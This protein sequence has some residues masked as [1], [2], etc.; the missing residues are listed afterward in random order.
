M[1]AQID[2][3]VPI[4]DPERPLRRTLQSIFTGSEGLVRVLV[5]A[6]NT[7]PAPFERI[8]ADYPDADLF[9]LNDGVR[10]PS[11]PMN[12]GLSNARAPWVSIMGSDDTV[13]A[14][15]YREW[16]DFARRTG[17]DIVIPRL[18]H[19]SGAAVI[20]PPTRPWR[21]HTLDPV[22]DRLS[23][24]SA[25]L[26]IFSRE[27]FGHARLP[28]G[29][30]TGEDIPFVTQLWFSGSRVGYAR[31]G[32]AYII[33]ADAGDRISYAPRP[34]EDEFAW[35]EPTE[36]LAENLTPRERRSLGAKL[37][38]VNL[39]G[40]IVSR[41]GQWNSTERRSLAAATV[42]MLRLGCGVEEV[43]SRA[44]RNVID[45]ALDASAPSTELDIAAALRRRFASPAG[46]L[47][48]DL[49]F[50]LSLDGAMRTA[51]SSALQ[52]SKLV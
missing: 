35:L 25:P 43:L 8:V 18:R 10:S 46:L 37:I 4:H 14:G 9:S 48:R 52:R 26:G 28:I 23:Y 5:I 11:G 27:R 51:F 21:T 6:H 16:W 40:T 17:S 45:L 33:Q 12:V 1:T 3:I 50:T 36:A 19:S 34:L 44:D 7:S 32:P 15:A 20:T 13:E 31:R 30:A 24:R 29:I 42:R 41:R 47:P 38:R 39:F 2:V 49:R 22:R